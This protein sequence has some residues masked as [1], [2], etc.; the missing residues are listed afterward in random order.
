MFFLLV[1]VILAC[2][3]GNGLLNSSMI[4]HDVGVKDFD[5]LSYENEIDINSADKDEL[6]QI[7][8]IGEIISGYI[9]DY[10][11]KFGRF[12]NVEQIKNIDGISDEI[13]EK[14]EPYIKLGGE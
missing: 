12:T 13:F 2:L 14:I 7:K 8:H 9:I 6:C 4:S 5:N 10:R 1:L 11:E 3:I